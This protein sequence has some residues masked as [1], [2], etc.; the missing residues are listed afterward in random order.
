MGTT[1]YRDAD[2]VTMDPGRPRASGLW[3]RDEQIVA[4]GDGEELARAAG[5]EAEVVGLSGSTIVPGLI[6]PHCHLTMLAY[7]LTGADCSPA[8]APS[9]AAIL[10]RLADQAAGPEGWVVGSGYAE[11][12]LEDGRHPTRAELDRVVPDAPCA[13]FHLSL[14]LVV[15]N[16][17]GLRALGLDETSPDP[18]NST[19]SRDA[20]GRLDGRLYEQIV[21]D[22][23]NA[24]LGAL[25][26]AVDGIGR[27]AVVRRAA[28]HL[29]GLG[30][31]SSS[32]AAADAAAFLALRE[33]ER[34][35]ELPIR[36][37]V[38][39]KHGDAGWLLEAGMSTGFGSERLR[40]G[41][42][43]LFC[44]GGMSSR[45]AAVDEP[46]LD[47]P[48]ETGLL[49]YE[50]AGLAT[51]VEACDRAGFQVAIHAQGER[52]IRTTLAAYERIAGSAVAGGGPNPARHRI[53]HG[54]CFTPELR[55]VAARLGIH[56]VT[57][58]AFLSAL[59]DGYLTA[60][61]Q[62][63]ADGLYPLASLIR[64]GVVVAGSSDAPV[65]GASPFVA[66]RDAQLRR[67]DTGKYVGRDEALT[68]EQALEL[69]TV[70][71]AFVSGRDDRLGSLEP[72][73]LADFVVLDRNPLTSAPASTAQ[74]VVRLTVVGG[75][76]VHREGIHA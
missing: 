48:G 41:A 27:A 43:K 25:L 20:D 8:A 60:F 69:Y 2:V 34:H 19:M 58:P 59:G 35:G 36:V 32:E 75:E 45:T 61:G 9:V 15:V 30:I 73:K 47:P 50:P 1:V 56:V 4:V 21:L 13:L 16:S 55:A 49:W 39:F 74:T 28:D 22:L 63:R 38:H 14:H 23:L 17:A 11:Y 64:E 68:A 62:A 31:T 71:A 66:I 26:R 24:N 44:D 76:V 40:I 3:V 67:T 12:L 10:D 53:E 37:G 7:L 65:I 6:D 72:G 51:I 18:P 57:Q 5:P 46:Y 29:A 42:I 33:A 70:R 52:G 54:G